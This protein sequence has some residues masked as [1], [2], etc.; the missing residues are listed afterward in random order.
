MPLPG[1]YALSLVMCDW[2]MVTCVYNIQCFVGC[3]CGHRCRGAVSCLWACV[4]MYAWD[5]V[6]GMC[7]IRGGCG[8]MMYAVAGTLCPVICHV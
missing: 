3:N 1:P 2:D 6:T 7:S 4:A 8:A 5:V